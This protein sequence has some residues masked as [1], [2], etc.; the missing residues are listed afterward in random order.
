MSG[1]PDSPARN[2]RSKRQLEEAIT[3]SDDGSDSGKR[4]ATL[5]GPKKR[6]KRSNV[7]SDEEVWDKA[8]AEILSESEL[9]PGV[10]SSPRC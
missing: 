1:A 6:Q 9:K 2:T 7:R 10:I 8:D 4:V 3:L 5:E